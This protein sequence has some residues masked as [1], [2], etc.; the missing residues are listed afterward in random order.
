FPAIFTIG[1]EPD[2]GASLLFVTMS[3]LFAN[4]PFG[5]LFGGLF[6]LLLF[7]AAITSAIGYLEPV[8]MTCKELFKMKRGTAVFASLA[9]IFIVGFPNILAHGI[10]SDILIRGMNL[11]DFT[12]YLSGN[13][14]MPLGALVLALYTLF[15][16]KFKNYQED[17]N[18]G[19]SGIKVF[20]WWKP[21]VSFVLPVVL[22]IIFVT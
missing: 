15:S 13:I 21:I 14:M 10:W 19:A 16:W 8:V 7:F 1:L 9:A 6:F 17:L 18:V 5:G 20:N 3:N 22:V 12:D 2:S 11:F 4:I